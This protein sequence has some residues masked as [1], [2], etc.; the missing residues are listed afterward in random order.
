[1]TARASRALLP[2]LVWAAALLGA[3][4]CGAKATAADGPGQVFVDG[5]PAPL[6]D[7]AP[8]NEP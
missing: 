3:T 7:G 4:G 1:M 5:P 6:S 8:P 2:A